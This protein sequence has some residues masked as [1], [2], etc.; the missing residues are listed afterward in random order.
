MVEKKRQM[1]TEDLHPQKTRDKPDL[2]PNSNAW[3]DL[4]PA[5]D[6]AREEKQEERSRELRNLG[7]D[8]LDVT[9]ELDLCEEAIWIDLIS[10][11]RTHSIQA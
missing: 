4:D 11:F 5:V 6:G 1:E 3:D 9:C 7:Q 8:M 2:M 10:A